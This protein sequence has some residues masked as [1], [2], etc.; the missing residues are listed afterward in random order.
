MV[1]IVA[2]KHSLVFYMEQNSSN[3]ETGIN[4]WIGSNN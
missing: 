1:D 3:I 2:I 4:S